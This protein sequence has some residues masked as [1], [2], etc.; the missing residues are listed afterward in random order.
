MHK[1][2]PYWMH[3]AVCKSIYV[4]ADRTKLAQLLHCTGSSS[5][6]LPSIPIYHFEMTDGL[7]YEI[8]ASWTLSLAHCTLCLVLTTV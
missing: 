3:A 1:G 7:T 4:V 8:I 2:A 6:L 5:G